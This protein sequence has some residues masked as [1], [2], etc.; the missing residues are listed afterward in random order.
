[1]IKLSIKERP[2]TIRGITFNNYEEFREYVLSNRISKEDSI[3]HLEEKMNSFEQKYKMSTQEFAQK[4]VGT[5]AEDTP[6]FIHWL[7]HYKS[8]CKLTDGNNGS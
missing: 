2:L 4:I 7:C 3:R 8:Y 5:P 6:D 1:M